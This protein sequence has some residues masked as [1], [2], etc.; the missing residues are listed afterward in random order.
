MR[1]V[2]P[3]I[4]L[5]VIRK[6]PL[7]PS[8]SPTTPKISAP[9]GRNAKPVANNA[10]AAISACVGSRPAKKIL[11]MTGARL[12]KMKKSYHSNAVP[13]DDA[14]TIRAID[15][16]LRSC[17]PATVAIFDFSPRERDSKAAVSV[18]LADDLGKARD[19]DA[20][21][22]DAHL[23]GNSSWSSRRQPLFEVE[24]VLAAIADSNALTLDVHADRTSCVGERTL[25]T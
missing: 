9:R 12:P 8:L 17:C 16:L 2:A 10:S 13:A 15:P 7:R 23:I 22:A 18:Q 11:E 20:E 6:A 21:T 24:M 25:E 5:T 1:N 4:R 3:P 14:M 19:D